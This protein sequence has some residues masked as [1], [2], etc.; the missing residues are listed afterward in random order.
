MIGIQ[1]AAKDSAER[2]GARGIRPLT[3]SFLPAIRVGA[4]DLSVAGSPPWKLDS[5]HGRRRSPAPSGSSRRAGGRG[6]SGTRS[7]ARSPRPTGR[8]C[9]RSGTPARASRGRCSSAATSARSGSWLRTGRSCARC[10]MTRGWW[11]PS[12]WVTCPV[13][14]SRCPRPATGWSARQATSSCPSP[15]SPR[16]EPGKD[17]GAC[18]TGE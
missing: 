11:S 17:P 1:S 12:P 18:C 13:P 15:P 8:T 5:R 7:R 4:P 14:G 3:G 2:L 10:P 16:R 9:G 6:V